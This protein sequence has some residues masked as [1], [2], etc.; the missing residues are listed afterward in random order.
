MTN[1]K[2]PMSANCTSPKS[3]MATIKSLGRTL[4]GKRRSLMLSKEFEIE[5]NSLL[6]KIYK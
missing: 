6:S 5:N 3:T 4:S 2:R 1:L